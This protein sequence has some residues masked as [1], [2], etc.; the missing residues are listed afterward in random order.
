MSQAPQTLLSVITVMIIA[1]LF[2]FSD[3]DLLLDVYRSSSLLYP[4]LEDLMLPVQCGD[5]GLLSPMVKHCHTLMPCMPA[6]A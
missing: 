5:R 2:L 3:A 4:G 6:T 1:E